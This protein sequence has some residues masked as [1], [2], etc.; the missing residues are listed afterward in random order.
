M[1][2]AHK[3]SEAAYR[4]GERWCLAVYERWA[5][6]GWAMPNEWPHTVEDAAAVLD[7]PLGLSPP[8][9]TWLAVLVDA[10][11]RLAWGQLLLSTRVNRPLPSS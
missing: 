4:E 5:E 11:A 6:R 2:F 8:V 9:R 3:L 10:C 7:L 1:E